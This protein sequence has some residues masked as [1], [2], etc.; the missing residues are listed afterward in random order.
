MPVV[1]VRAPRSAPARRGRITVI[2]GVNGAGK[3]SI[4][5]AAI[6]QAGGRYFNPDEEA[7][8]IRRDDPN[9]P[10]A[11]ANALAWEMGRLGLERAI[12][13]QEDFT[14][15]T[16]LGGRTI[17][18]LLSQALDA[19][20]E[21]IVRYVGL[22]SPERHVARVRARVELGGHD[23][24]E[25]LVRARYTASRVNLIA[26][27]PRLTDLAVYDNSVEL[28][29]NR[30]EEPAPTLLLEMKNGRIVSVAPKEHIPLWA[31]PIV[32]AAILSDRERRGGE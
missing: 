9:V 6:R 13:R 3:S 12:A 27:L 30:G 20:L 1:P 2:A 11:E 29:P 23:I 4:V 26:L 16:T 24:P 28:D 22:D 17:A 31:H 32:A 14:F 7:R 18:A 8:A 15:E 10:E 25:S 19:G 21:V 5:G